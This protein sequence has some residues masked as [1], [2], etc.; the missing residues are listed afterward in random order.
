[1]LL[2]PAAFETLQLNEHVAKIRYESTSSYFN[3]SHN[4]CL[5]MR[6]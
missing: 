6:H 4:F 5:N 1:M 3:F 2:F